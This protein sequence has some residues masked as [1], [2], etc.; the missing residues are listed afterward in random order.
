MYNVR[1]HLLLTIQ[2]FVCCPLPIAKVEVT[3]VGDVV[4]VVSFLS[5]ELPEL[6]SFD[7]QLG[8]QGGC[9]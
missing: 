7:S 3:Q 9:M 8:E 5:D 2:L 6:I 1:H 4:Q